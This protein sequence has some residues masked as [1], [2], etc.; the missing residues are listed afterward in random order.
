MTGL[1]STWDRLVVG[2]DADAARRHVRAAGVSFGAMLAGGAVGGARGRTEG[3][4]W[5]PNPNGAV[6]AVLPVYDSAI[7]SIYSPDCDPLLVDLLAWRLDDPGHWYHRTGDCPALLNIS[8]ARV[9]PFLSEPLHVWSTPLAWLHAGT[10]GVVV[11]DPARARKWLIS[12]PEVVAENVALAERL[13]AIIRQPD[14]HLPRVTVPR[15]AIAA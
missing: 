12:V 2:P 8:E 1:R 13:D 9:R 3:R 5:F 15:E 7:P 6:L 11:L 14:P 10:R 4:S